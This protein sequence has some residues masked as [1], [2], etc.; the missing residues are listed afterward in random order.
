MV[1]QF[2]LEVAILQALELMAEVEQEANP[3]AK[4]DEGWSAGEV[5]DWDDVLYNPL[6]LNVS[7]IKDTAFDI[8]GRTPEEIVRDIPKSWRILHMESVLHPD[9]VK[10]F[11]EYKQLLVLKLLRPLD[12]ASHLTLVSTLLN[13]HPL[14][15][16]S[17]LRE[18]IRLQ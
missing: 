13:P 11:W 4:V 18:V 6:G 16:V 7:T 10:R 17:P 9:L 14:R 2:D 5:S 15:L 3:S 1:K 8:L 12:Q